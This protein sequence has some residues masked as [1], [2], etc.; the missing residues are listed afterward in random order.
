MEEV[1][2]AQ[3]QSG[4]WI[5]LESLN[6]YKRICIGMVFEAF[7]FLFV[8]CFSSLTSIDQSHLSRHTQKQSAWR[9]TDDLAFLI[10]FL[11][12]NFCRLI[13]SCLSSPTP[14]SPLKLLIEL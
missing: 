4:Y 5:L 11:T 2:S 1:Q 13:K 8:A 14:F 6:I 12:L 10:P 3:L 9:A 7:R